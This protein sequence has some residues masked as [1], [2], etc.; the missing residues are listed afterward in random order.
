MG[1]TKILDKIVIQNLEV[2]CQNFL[3]I[4][5]KST[6]QN[7]YNLESDKFNVYFPKKE[8]RFIC[9]LYFKS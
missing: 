2:N 4:E 8:A 1:Q 3:E 6:W 5:I 7:N 9:E